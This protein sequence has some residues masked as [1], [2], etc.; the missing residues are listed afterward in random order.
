MPRAA[1]VIALG[2]AAVAGVAALA[3]SDGG[4]APRSAPE[5]GPDA[6]PAPGPV[7]AAPAPRILTLAHAGRTFR[8]APDD[9]ITLRLDGTN[10][11]SEPTVSGA[12]VEA[13]RVAYV[14]DPGYAEWELRAARP[15]TAT[16]ESKGPRTFRVTLVVPAR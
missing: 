4:G 2:L 7:T 3:V 5:G 14:Q 15:G 12:A 13:V 8:L 16:I 6:S 11:W 10:S 9:A 1:A